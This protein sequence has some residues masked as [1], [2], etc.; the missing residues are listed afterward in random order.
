M[1]CDLHNHSPCSDGSV[2][3]ERISEVAN[4]LTLNGLSSLESRFE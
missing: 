1:S 4:N 3:I 2:P